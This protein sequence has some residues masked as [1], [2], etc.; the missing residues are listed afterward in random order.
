MIMEEKLTAIYNQAVKIL[1][2]V[3]ICL[4]HSDV[5]DLAGGCGARVVGETVFFTKEVIEQWLDKAPESF[6]LKARNPSFDS[7]IGGGNT[8]HAAGYGC[9]EIYE[10]DGSSRRTTL[11]DYI[12][13]TKLVH[14]SDHFAINGGILA[15][16]TEIP[17]DICNLVMIY[18]AMLASDKC[19]LGIPGD[20]VFMEQ[21]MEMAGILAADT[22][23]LEN[24]HRVITLISTI[25]P[26]TIDETALEAMQVAAK[27]RQPLIISPA[28]TTG[29]TG[30][31]DLAGN[32]SLATAEALAAMVV[33]Q[34]IHPGT[35]VVF[36]PQCNIGNMHT[37]GIST[38]S[39]AFSIQ[40]KYTAALAGMLKLPSRSGGAATD[41]MYLSAQSSGEGMLS[42]LTS[43]QNGVSIILH[44]AGILNNYAAMSYEKFI[45]DLEM[46]DLIKSYTSGF[47]VD[48]DTMNLDLIK[49][50]GHGG[51]FLTSSDT[52]EKCRKN[53]LDTRVAVRGVTDRKKAKE[54]YN[55]NI[56]LQLSQML[57]SY[58][59]PVLDKTVAMKLDDF[60]LRS[61]VP[62]PLLDRVKYLIA[63]N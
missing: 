41:A 44:S 55:E 9:P 37:G 29:T 11:E 15:Q 34:M 61:N 18:S 28:P 17:A 7:I 2:Q 24:G 27:Y 39:A 6:L 40:A 58:E 13:F 47:T 22:G 12:K 19:L 25:S 14:Q 51:Q 30:P 45:A 62:Q 33:V 57:S 31:I 49:S 16:P 52:M 1:E 56:T 36:G 53:Y 42:L 8:V 43:C 23:G 32:L 21:V 63:D 3:G 48:D 26:L 38:G 10:L 54:K 50:V 59:Q 35:P 5:R 60:M 4:K 20:A 46:L